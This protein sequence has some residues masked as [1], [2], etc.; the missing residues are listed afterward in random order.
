MKKQVRISVLT[1]LLLAPGAIVSANEN[2]N[3]ATIEKE[4]KSNIP[5]NTLADLDVDQIRL[6]EIM[7]LNE[8]SALTNIE[9][10]YDLLNDLD[11]NN[12]LTPD[13]YA[14][15]TAKLD[16]LNALKDLK[17]QAA[18]LTNSISL[19]KLTNPDLLVSVPSMQGKYETLVQSF[20]GVRADLDLAV[21]DYSSYSTPD[22][23]QKAFS[24]MLDYLKDIEGFEKEYIKNAST[25]KTYIEDIKKPQK[26]IYGSDGTTSADGYIERL[27]KFNGVSKDKILEFKDLVAEL[28]G[29]YASRLTANEKKIVDSHLLSNGV[30]VTALMKSAQVDIKAAEA[31]DAQIATIATTEFKTAATFSSKIKAINLAYSKLNTRQKDLAEKYSLVLGDATKKDGYQHALNVVDRI[32]ALKASSTDAYR[33]AVEAVEDAYAELDASMQKYVLNL[34]LLATARTDI[35]AAIPVENDIQN[36][37]T[38]EDVKAARA[39]YNSLS[40]NQKKLVQNYSDLQAWEKTASNSLRVIDQ[41]NKI[42]IENKKTFETTVTSAEKAYEKLGTENEKQLVS[43]STRLQYLLPFA[44]VTG[45]FYNLKSTATD[46]KKQVKDLLVALEALTVDTN[47]SEA[48]AASLTKLKEELKL[49]VTGLE[50]QLD[51]AEV[52]IN[53][54]NEAAKETLT[55]SAKLQAILDARAAYNSMTD[56]QAKK[57]VTNLKTL[58]DLERTVSQPVTVTKTIEAVDPEHSSFAS[59]AK[60]AITAY[61]R[62]TASQKSYISDENKKRIEDFKISLAFMDQIKALT[63]TKEGFKT[64]VEE[65]RSKYIELTGDSS[66]FASTL[67]D[68]LKDALS[69]YESTISA[70][71]NAITIGS[72]LVARIDSLSLLTGTAFLKEIEAI[73]AAYALLPAD[74]KKQV[75]NYKSF[76]TLKK[77]GTTALKVVDLIRDEMIITVN[78]A[79]RD[80]ARKVEAA[81]KAYDRLTGRQK[82]YVYNYDAGLK[83]YLKIA[84]IV[85]QIN[86]L[87]PTSRTYLEDVAQIRMQYERLSQIEQ[88]YL[89]D[90]LYKIEAAESGLATVTEVMDLIDAAVPGAENYVEKLIAARAA[91]DKLAR[92]NSAYQKLVLNY[93][94]LTNREK[95]LK[96][97]TTVIYQIQEL[98]EMLTRPYNDALSF[99]RKY[100]TAVKAYEKIDYDSRQLV[101]N[102]EVLLSTIYP[103]A[104][105]MEAISLIKPT[106]KTFAEEVLRARALYDA[107]SP[108]DKALISNY[109][110]LVAYENTVVGGLAVDELIRAI[111]T[112]SANQYMQAIKDARAAYNALSVAE[113]R[114]VTLYQELVSYE[115]GVK[116]VLIAIDLIDGLQHSTNLVAQYD[117]VVKALEK[118]TA[119]Q[120]A[121][122]PNLNKLASIGP[123][124]EV[125]KMI[126]K[127]KPSD[128]A[129]AGSIQAAISAYNRLSS[130][131]KFYV[132]N[133]SKLEQARKDTDAVSAVIDKISEISPSSKNYAAQVRAALAAYNSLPAAM[134]RLVTNYS[135]LKEAEKE[136]AAVEKVRQLISEIDPSSYYFDRKVEAARMAYDKLTAQQK[137]MVSNYFML[138]EYEKQLWYW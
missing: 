21:N 9:V 17:S 59:K 88:G 51:V 36:I 105:T 100:T 39:A 81:L 95:A 107:L 121:M 115:K 2:V 35:D 119:E 82:S 125:Y 71:E 69:I 103:V 38:A 7:D 85:S 28:N 134:K 127:L 73:E 131:E 53:L 91:Y 112:K 42:K 113:K 68:K 109:Q 45:T 26:F 49:S 5:Y 67:K 138:E 90:I 135:V 72:T 97:V 48:D 66:P 78:V 118:L 123:A 30:T 10:Y 33:N 65:A 40:S 55:G 122:I 37:K 63:P 11:Y 133:Y 22:F 129:Y 52:V 20:K 124:I 98:Q 132:T 58:T 13:E 12:K 41:I 101:T 83:P 43:N 16:Y 44:K 77:D 79:H 80:Y 89:A 23:E 64:L 102:R 34:N 106:S 128:P 108:A 6:Q 14:L 54:I 136:V 56:A 116:N 84:D 99:V 120:R 3:P 50:N 8:K 75:T 25:L 111:P 114:A 46:Y 70:H 130:A 110:A 86:A 24:T 92:I 27:L 32:T 19:L 4:D 57:L 18:G 93:K 47:A 137:R 126:E 87:K 61:V 74:A 104:S 1:G 29:E 94:D 117:K 31:L 76:T 62:L 15:L 96:P 60:S